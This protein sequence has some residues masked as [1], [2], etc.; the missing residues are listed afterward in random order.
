MGTDVNWLFDKLDRLHC[1]PVLECSGTLLFSL[2]DR[3][4]DMNS[5]FYYQHIQQSESGEW[6]KVR[7]LRNMT[8]TY[9]QISVNQRIIW[10]RS[11]YLSNKQVTEGGGA[12][13][14]KSRQTCAHDVC[15]YVVTWL[16][17]TGEQNNICQTVES[18]AH[19]TNPEHAD[20][21]LLGV[22]GFFTEGFSSSTPKYEEFCPI[23][24][25]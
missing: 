8:Q 22:S 1:N 10:N 11:K 13:G 9:G 21:C 7:H 5:G 17:L 20:E 23:N 4:A 18:A 3:Y 15:I 6:V 24:T 25:N 14:Q 19:V 2:G 12:S 16:R